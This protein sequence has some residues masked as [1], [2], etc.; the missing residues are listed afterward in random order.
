VTRIVL[1]LCVALA[2]VAGCQRPIPG[3]RPGPDDPGRPTVGPTFQRFPAD[4]ARTVVFGVK[5]LNADGDPI[6]GRITI[7]VDVADI[8]GGRGAMAHKFPIDT[9][10]DSGWED[11]AQVGRDY[12]YEVVFVLRA[13]AVGLSPGEQVECYLQDGDPPFGFWDRKRNR[14]P[15]DAKVPSAPRTV[16][17]TFSLLPLEGAGS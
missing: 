2:A 12:R 1:A 8:K 11:M 6:P 7:Y 9:T 15:H 13:T 14:V 4:V 3:Q 17:C 5:L 10:V 16:S